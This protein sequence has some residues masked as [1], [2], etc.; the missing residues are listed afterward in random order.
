MYSRHSWLLIL[1]GTTVVMLALLTLFFPSAAL[2]QCGTP[3]KSRCFT[4]HARQDPIADKGEWHVV[5]A[6]KDIC[7]NC[8]GGNGTS[9]VAAEA[10]AG[11]TVQPLSDIYT[12]CHSCH[13]D[14]YMA[15]A[16][17]FA[18]TLG[19]T[20][21]SC[22]TP[23]PAPLEAVS[24]QRIVSQPAPAEPSSH[25]PSAPSVIFDVAVAVFGLGLAVTLILRRL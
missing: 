4:C 3:E 10:H 25:P 19:E 17:R 8:H 1:T 14:D 6:S 15:R 23:T 7:I 12:D 24:Y 5:H 22:A 11:M 18:N 13:P 2:A 16:Q 9:T 20:V 21:G